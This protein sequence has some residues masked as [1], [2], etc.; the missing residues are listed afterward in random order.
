MSD[1][2]NNLETEI[3]QPEYDFSA[4]VRG[5][6]AKAFHEGYKVVIRRQDGSAE[7]REYELPEGFVHI[8]PDVRVYFPDTESVNNAL[9]GLI[10]LI[11][12]SA[13]PKRTR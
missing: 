4:A 9:R 1:M 6:H 13:T 8:D 2:P 7:E 5:K 11:P 12:E 10:R 3:M